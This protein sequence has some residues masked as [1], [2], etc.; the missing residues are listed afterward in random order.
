MN[1]RSVAMITVEVENFR[2]HVELYYDRFE[3][4]I[5][6]GTVLYDCTITVV[7]TYV[8]RSVSI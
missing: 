6:W 1:K 3:V 8:V 5:I 2:K 4:T 7:N